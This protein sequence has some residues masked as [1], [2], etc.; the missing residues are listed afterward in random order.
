MGFIVI[1]FFCGLSAGVIG[2]IKGASF[3]LWFAVGFCLPLFGTLVALVSRREE[4]LGT[5][6]CPECGMV[7]ALYDQ[8]CRRCGADLEFPE[9]DEEPEPHGASPGQ[10][11]LFGA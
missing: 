1:L 8:V 4:G 9:L 11:Q 10:Q 6:P 3:F 5:R 7:L 2:K